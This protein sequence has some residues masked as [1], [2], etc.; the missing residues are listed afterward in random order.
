MGFLRY[1][2]IGSSDRQALDWAMDS[3]G[4]IAEHPVA[5]SEPADEP[6][7]DADTIAA[8]RIEPGT[9]RG[10]VKLAPHLLDPDDTRLLAVLDQLHE[11]HPSVLWYVFDNQPPARMAA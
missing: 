11:R 3:D 7:F 6:T 10:S 4:S 5:T 1:L 9:R 8:G 2:D